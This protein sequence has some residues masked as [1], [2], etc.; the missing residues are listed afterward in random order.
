MTT[1]VSPSGITPQ[2]MVS[3]GSSVEATA[4]GNDQTAMRTTAHEHAIGEPAE[5]DS[6]GAGDPLGLY[7]FLVLHTAGCMHV[8]SRR[9]AASSNGCSK[10]TI[11]AMHRVKS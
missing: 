2:R 3:F 6:Q 10:S 1:Q 8:L 9:P 7:L 5:A 4:N 11:S